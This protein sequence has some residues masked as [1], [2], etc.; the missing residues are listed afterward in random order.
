MLYLQ[1]IVT[2]NH[3]TISNILNEDMHCLPSSTSMV[4]F[5]N[6]EDFILFLFT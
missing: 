2:Q 4:L 3:D 1:I 6:L 5:S